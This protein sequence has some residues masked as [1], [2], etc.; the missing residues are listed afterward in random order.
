MDPIEDSE[1]FAGGSE[2]DP[3]TAT[4]RHVDVAA[5]FILIVDLEYPV[6]VVGLGIAAVERDDDGAAEGVSERFVGRAAISVD[7]DGKRGVAGE[8]AESAER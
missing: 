3:G 5:M 8:R 2:R 1:G 6:D 4:G 7:E